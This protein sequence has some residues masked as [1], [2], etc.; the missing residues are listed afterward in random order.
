MIPLDNFR[1]L[2]SSAWRSIIWKSLA[3]P[4]SLRVPYRQLVIGISIF[5][6]F[7]S[8]LPFMNEIVLTKSELAKLQSILNTNEIYFPLYFRVFY[9]IE[10]ISIGYF[11]IEFN[12]RIISTPK[13]SLIFNDI[14]NILDFVIIRIHPQ[15]ILFFFV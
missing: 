4:D 5:F 15:L 2:P 7:L 9:L 6:T 14:F 10:I 12:F 13:I 3:Y 11:T 8:C 1:F